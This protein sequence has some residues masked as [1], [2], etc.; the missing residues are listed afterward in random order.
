MNHQTSYYCNDAST[1]QLRQDEASTIQ[2][3]N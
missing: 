1:L 2:A 3:V